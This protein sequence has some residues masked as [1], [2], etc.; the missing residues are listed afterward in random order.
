VRSYGLVS[1]NWIAEGIQATA[2]LGWEPWLVATGQ[3]A[4]GAER[5]TPSR[6]RWLVPE[7]PSRARRARDLGLLRT[8]A[9][10]RSAS[11]LPPLRTVRPA[12]AH[13]HFGWAAAEA[14]AA[15]VEARV[16][17][18]ATF[19]GSDLTIDPGRRRSWDYRRLLRAAAA[20]IVVSDFLARKLPAFG[21]DREAHVIPMGIDLAQL[22]LRPERRLPERP[23]VLFVGRLV[24]FKGADVLVQAVPEVLRAFPEARFE[25]IGDGPLRDVCAGLVRRHGLERSVTLS[26]ALPRPQ[27]YER[28]A[29]AD[30]VVVPSRDE[31]NGRAEGRSVLAMEAQA[32][33]AAVVATDNGGLPETFPPEHRADLARAGDPASLAAALVARLSRPGDWRE[34]ALVARSWVE[35]NFAWPEIGRRIDHVYRTV[36]DG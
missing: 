33:G 26:G 32:V 9:D 28:L 27:V 20:V 14:R 19:H 12:L 7:P 23:T 3:I 13:A 31:E 25:V 6:D 24:G 11:L 35:R 21:F 16:P 34:R 18:V 29:A 30:V 5:L 15:A 8:S 36:A 10:R 1:E 17:L 22:P 4:D 2:E